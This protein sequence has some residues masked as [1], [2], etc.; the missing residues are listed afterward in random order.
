M[1]IKR[2]K[3]KDGVSYAK[4]K[5]AGARP[6]GSW[7]NKNALYYC[8]YPMIDS[9]T[10]DISFGGDLQAWDDFNNVLVVDDDFGQPFSPFYAKNESPILEGSQDDK[11]SFLSQVI[12]K[13]NQI[14]DSL[15][16]LEVI[17]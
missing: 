1:I 6:G 16:Y 10:L 12:E 15:D 2:Y 14:M 8:S 13:Y 9:I 4:L 11:T 17:D 3:L 7:I 5:L